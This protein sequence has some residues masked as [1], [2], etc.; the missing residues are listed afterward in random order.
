ME[1]TPTTLQTP[2]LLSSTCSTASIQ[3]TRGRDATA[4]ISLER[5]E[6]RVAG[7]GAPEHADGVE[8]EAVEID[9]GCHVASERRH[10]QLRPEQP[11]D[12]AHGAL[13][14]AQRVGEGHRLGYLSVR[15]KEGQRKAQ[16]DL[17]EAGK[18]VHARM[19]LL[20][21][22]LASWAEQ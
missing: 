16:Q 10:P 4:G 22:P 2:W 6:D 15:N 21:G 17:V 18:N 13:S 14:N 7:K 9:P 20:R 11:E 12:D 5:R 3:A 19:P 1:H 8:V